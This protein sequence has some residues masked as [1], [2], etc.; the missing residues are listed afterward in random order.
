MLHHFPSKMAIVRA[1]V[2]HLHAKRLRAFRK[3]VQRTPVQVDRVRA[4]PEENLRGNASREFGCDAIAPA[5]LD[6][7]QRI[8]AT[9]L[10]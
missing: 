3:A 2:V 1:A 6:P 10:R 7:C 8:L 9:H 5:R 4:Y